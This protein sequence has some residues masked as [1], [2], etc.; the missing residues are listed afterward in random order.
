MEEESMENCFM[1][2]ENHKLKSW[3]LFFLSE[4]GMQEKKGVVILCMN[5]T[6]ENTAVM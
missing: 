6:E 1:D 3:T 4:L 2:F 5:E